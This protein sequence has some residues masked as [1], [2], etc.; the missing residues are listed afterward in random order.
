MSLRNIRR[1]TQSTTGKHHEIS[2]KKKTWRVACSLSTLTELSD[3]AAEVWTRIL[4]YSE[5]TDLRY[6]RI[7]RDILKDFVVYV[8]L[9]SE[10]RKITLK[11]VTTTFL[12][13]RCSAYTR[14]NS[15]YATYTSLLKQ[16]LLITSLICGLVNEYQDNLRIK[17]KCIWKIHCD[18]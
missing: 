4:G 5:P 14:L 12:S 3:V 15:F 18:A 2:H 1:Y 7:L 10:L 17:K 11:Q 13:P 6:Y 8:G 9:L 16:N